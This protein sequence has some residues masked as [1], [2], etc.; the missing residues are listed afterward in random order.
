MGDA[1]TKGTGTPWGAPEFQKPNAPQYDTNYATN[2]GDY[3]KGPQ[4]DQIRQQVALQGGDAARQYGANQSKMLGGNG[5]TSGSNAGQLAN[6]AAQTEQAGNAGTLAAA[7]QQMDAFNQA[8]AAKNK[9]L[10]DQY[11]Q[12]LG[13]YGQEQQGRGQAI[14]GLEGGLGSLLGGYLGRR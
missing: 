8:K 2:V 5:T 9:I 7:L 4:V 12:E 14:A 1:L 3:M 10:S 13:A 11:G 6:I